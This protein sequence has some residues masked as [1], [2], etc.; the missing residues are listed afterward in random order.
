MNEEYPFPRPVVALALLAVIVG[1]GLGQALPGSLTGIDSMIGVVET[2]AALLTQ[3]SATLLMAQALRTALLL[4]FTSNGN[5]LWKVVLGSTTLLMALTTLFAALLSHNQLAPQ[6]TAL[7]A[8]MVLGT[9]AYSGALALQDRER[10]GLGLIVLGVACTGLLHTLA[11]VVALVAASRASGE[12]FDLARGLTTMAF[13]F[14]S[15]CLGASFIWLLRPQV[16]WLKTAIGVVGVLTVL[17]ALFA[18]RPDGWGFVAG[19]TL[20]QLSAHPDPF[21]PNVVRY[22]FE[23]WGLLAALG[24][25]V[26]PKR[27]PQ[28]LMALG[29]CLLGRSSADVP[30][31][32][33][34]LLNGALALQL[35]RNTES[36]PAAVAA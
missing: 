26:L 17:G 28:L 20:E 15:V 2:A 16:S 14:E 5:P 12:G 22:T 23:L 8:T 18:L 19:R 11:R 24:C 31:G 7:S 29:L 1:R 13:S 25:L 10:R 3:L 36:T 30:I 32:A 33:V 4:L 34:F 21:L 6:W 9:L 27:A 35:G